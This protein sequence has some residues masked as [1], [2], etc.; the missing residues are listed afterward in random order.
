SLNKSEIDQI[1][2][3]CVTLTPR[4][5]FG[6]DLSLQLEKS[7]DEPYPLA[8]SMFDLETVCQHF[9]GK[10]FLE[11]IAARSKL[12]GRVQIG[13]EL[14]FA[15]YFLKYGHL[16]VKDGTHLAD[17]FSGVFDRRWHREKGINVPEPANPPVEIGMTRK[18]NRIVIDKSYEQTETIQIAPEIYEHITAHPMIK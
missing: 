6:T 10:Q 8:V 14:N 1:F 15:G 17:D 5:P 18:G 13:D 3:L 11:Y 4:G 12:H 2:I 9:S 7:V 16:T